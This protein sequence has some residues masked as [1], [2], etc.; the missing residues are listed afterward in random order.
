MRRLNLDLRGLRREPPG[1]GTAPPPLPQGANSTA[2]SQM[3][4][5][6][7]PVTTSNTTVTGSQF[8]KVSI[9]D[10]KR[11]NARETFEAVVQKW[12]H[13]AHAVHFSPA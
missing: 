7:S 4:N 13:F 1:V 9:A 3:C 10:E 8:I 2:P 5:L 6:T 12:K 11:N